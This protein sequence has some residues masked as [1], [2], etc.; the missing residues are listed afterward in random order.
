LSHFKIISLLIGLCFPFLTEAQAMHFTPVS[1]LEEYNKLVQ[2]NRDLR[3]VEIST[4]IPDV[5]LDLRYAAKNNFTGKRM[6]PAQTK[7]TYLRYPAAR[8]LANA[9]VELRGMNIGFKIWDAYRPYHVT[10]KFWELIHDERYV[11]NPAKGSGHN[12]GIAVDLTLYD[13][14]T[15]K[16]LNMPTGFDDFSDAAHH[17]K[18][19]PDPE[20]MKNRE[21]LKSIMEKH[22]FLRF[23]T[24]WWHYYWSG[25]DTF[26]VMDIPFKKLHKSTN[27]T[28]R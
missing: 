25:A 11:A 19:L 18:V 23:E 28:K 15:G 13:L 9:A 21:L 8:A 22:G 4:I 10:V 16:E 1:S 12:R 3:L 17:G 2:G 14:T 7:K 20:K 5:I 6:Y 27:A 26:D 24:E